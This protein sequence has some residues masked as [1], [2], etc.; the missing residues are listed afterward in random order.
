MEKEICRHIWRAKKD[1]RMYPHSFRRGPE[2]QFFFRPNSILRKLVS[3]LAIWGLTIGTLP[4]YAAPLPRYG[5]P[6]QA[7]QKALLPQLPE[8][9]LQ[10]QMA[11]IAGGQPEQPKFALQKPT[12][13]LA[14]L[15]KPAV[16]ALQSSSAIGV[17]VGYADSS[18]PSLNFP[19]PWQDS[20]NIVFIGGG[21][22]VNAG[23]IRIDN[24][25]SAPLTVDS[26]SVDLQR[27]NAQFN[28][29][30]S[31]T[32]PAGASA[33]LTQTQLGNFDTSAFSIVA[34][35]RPL[36]AGETRIPRITVTIAG[37]PQ[38]FLDTSHVLDTGGFDLSCRG[39]ES[40]QWRQVGASGIESPGGH[41]TLGPPSQSGAGGSPLS[42]T[43]QLTDASGAALANV[44]VGFTVVSGPNSGQTG[45]DV[46]DSQ[47]NARF[48]YI[49]SSQ[50]TDIIQASVV[51][52]S[53]ATIQSSQ[54]AI[55]WQTASCGP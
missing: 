53:G 48:T 40:L 18:A 37:T 16:T 31:F 15:K 13:R 8:P 26:L 52:A 23:A 20:P 24:P 34:C 55:S 45:K 50:G 14:A 36:A 42:A 19:T 21:A 10:K 6:V 22:P 11:R 41:L 47:G 32:I 25:G 46:T 5:P 54:A 2:F 9:L 29:W 49:S 44:T 39:N 51:N 35:G 33:V 27:A 1:F 43:A 4:A 3:L 17:F 38:T 12:T 30:G 28:L 7:G